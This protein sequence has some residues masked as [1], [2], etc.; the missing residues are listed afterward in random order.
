MWIILSRPENL[1]WIYYEFTVDG[2]VSDLMV[3][4]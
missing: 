4:W 1:P 2:T 3:C